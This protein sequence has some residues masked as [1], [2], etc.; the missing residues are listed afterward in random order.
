MTDPKSGNGFGVTDFRFV[1]DANDGHPQLELDYR[2]LLEGEDY[3]H[4]WIR[5]MGPE[6]GELGPDGMGEYDGALGQYRMM[7]PFKTTPASYAFRQKYK[8]GQVYTL[9]ALE[10]Y[11]QPLKF[12]VVYPPDYSVVI[13][14]GSEKEFVFKDPALYHVRYLGGTMK[15]EMFGPVP[16]REEPKVLP[17]SDPTLELITAEGRFKADTG[18]WY[19]EY[20]DAEGRRITADGGDSK[21]FECGKVTDPCV[22]ADANVWLTFSEKPDSFSVQCW[23]FRGMENDAENSKQVKVNGDT[24]QLEKGCYMYRVVAD[25]RGEDGSYKGI[26]YYFYVELTD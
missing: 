14:V 18:S 8:A 16:E 25:W 1:Q 15:I 17:S 20:T 24:F 4:G 19:A 13:Y 26:H 11:S 21:P 9:D 3:F 2:F 5:K 23:P 10:R 7:I 6:E 12:K 22:T